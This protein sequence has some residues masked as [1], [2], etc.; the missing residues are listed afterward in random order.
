VCETLAPN[1]AAQRIEKAEFKVDQP[2]PKKSNYSVARSGNAGIFGGRCPGIARANRDGRR[3]TRYR[4][5]LIFVIS[6]LN[7]ILQRFRA[8]FA[9]VKESFIR[10]AFI[11][12]D[13]TRST[14]S[15][16]RWT[17][18]TRTGA[19]VMRAISWNL[20]RGMG[21]RKMMI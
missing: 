17:P 16:F 5:A 21:D 13:R 10:T 14:N 15:F 9:K 19:S 18:A 7:L 3:D 20:P 6:F 1:A 4:C 2:F 12:R 8:A 11:K